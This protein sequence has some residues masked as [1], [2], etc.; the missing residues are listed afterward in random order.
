MKRNSW[1]GAFSYKVYFLRYTIEEKYKKSGLKK[2]LAFGGQRI[3]FNEDFSAMT[4]GK[5]KALAA[6]IE[7]AGLTGSSH[8]GKY[9]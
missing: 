3:V 9:R 7:T 6:D 5:R 1:H 8:P 4:M 2:N